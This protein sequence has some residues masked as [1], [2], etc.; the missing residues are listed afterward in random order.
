MMWVS[1][2]LKTMGDFVDRHFP[3]RGFGINQIYFF[4]SKHIRNL[5]NTQ[6]AGK[7]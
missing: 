7:W 1:T 2:V 5:H 6:E 3:E 4:F